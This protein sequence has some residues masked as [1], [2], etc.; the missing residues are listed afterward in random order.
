MR[1]IL[2]L[3]AA[4]H[5]VKGHEEGCP[6]HLVEKILE[7]TQNAVD[8]QHTREHLEELLHKIVTR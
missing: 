6:T 2:S 3:L 7:D 8:F 1:L 4:L 5:A